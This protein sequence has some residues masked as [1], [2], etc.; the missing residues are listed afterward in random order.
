MYATTPGLALK[1]LGDAGKKFFADYAAKFGETKEPYSIM[2]YDAMGAALQAIED[3]CATAGC[4]RDPGPWRPHLTL[5]RVRSGEREVGRAL[6]TS[7]LMTTELEIPAMSINTVVLMRSDL[8]P[9]GPRHTPLGIHRLES[10][11][12][13]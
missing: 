2:G 6:H 9:A 11:S 12:K 10:R 8:L 5:A 1:D 3:V 7:Q 4:T 13:A